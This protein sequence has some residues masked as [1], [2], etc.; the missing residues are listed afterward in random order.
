M[1][2]RPIWRLTSTRGRDTGA[3]YPPDLHARRS[4]PADRPLVGGI[5]VG[6][7]ELRPCRLLLEGGGGR[8]AA[9]AGRRPR[10]LTELVVAAVPGAPVGRAL[11][12]PETGPQIA[13]GDGRRGPG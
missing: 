12:C 4:A 5:G 11:T 13:V 2:P 7:Q 6:R 10:R 1:S 8:V 9:S 3:S